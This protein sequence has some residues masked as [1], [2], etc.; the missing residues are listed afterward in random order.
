[1]LQQTFLHVPGISK[2][3]ESHIWQNDILNWHEFHQQCHSLDLSTS[4]IFKIKEKW[5]LQE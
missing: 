3:V 5:Q 4:K 1:M 2:E